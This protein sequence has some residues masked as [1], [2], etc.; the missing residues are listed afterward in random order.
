MHWARIRDALGAGAEAATREGEERDRGT[1]GGR[2]RVFWPQRREPSFPLPPRDMRMHL[3]FQ[4]TPIIPEASGFTT[5]RSFSS[6]F[7][8]FEGTRWLWGISGKVL[9]VGDVQ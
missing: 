4:G 1:R 8:G 5:Q 3:M 6:P 7:W 2:G 9:V